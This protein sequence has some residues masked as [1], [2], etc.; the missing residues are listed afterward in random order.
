MVSGATFGV[1]PPEG[2]VE[3]LCPQESEPVD[4]RP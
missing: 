4:P 3:P 1:P 2:A